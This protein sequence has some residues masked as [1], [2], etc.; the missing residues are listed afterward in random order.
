MPNKLIINS[1]LF[2]FISST[3][4]AC[5][6]ENNN[7]VWD[8]IEPINRQVFTLNMLLD[9][10]AVRPISRGYNYITP[11]LAK[12]GISNHLKWSKSPISFFNSALQTKPHQAFSDLFVFSVNALSLGFYEFVDY[13]KLSFETFDKT[14]SHYNIA[15]GAYL[16]IPILGSSSMRGISSRTIDFV[17]NPLKLLNENYFENHQNTSV[18]LEIL[19]FRS[20]NSDYIDSLKTESLDPYSKFRSIYFQQTNKNNLYDQQDN[21]FIDN[22][23]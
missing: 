23:D 17:A 3:I 7:E 8:P 9:T 16:V 10:Y 20:T 5:S 1:F 4:C 11:R 21:F 13:Q 18:T 14:L 15:S 19:D 12:K 6:K 2:L 22:E